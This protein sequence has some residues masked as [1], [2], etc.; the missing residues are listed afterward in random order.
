MPAS[1]NA[2]GL[3]ETDLAEPGVA[4]DAGAT[5][6]SPEGFAVPP[7][8]VPGDGVAVAA[9]LAAADGVRVETT[10][11]GRPPQAEPA[12]ARAAR[13]AKVTAARA[14]RDDRHRMGVSIAAA[15]SRLP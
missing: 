6:V 10:A 9:A 4:V 3:A 13:V 14:S 12:A 8:V 7:A 15:K 1:V 5:V 11:A 2:P